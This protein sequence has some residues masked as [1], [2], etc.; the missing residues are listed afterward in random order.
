MAKVNKSIALA[1]AATYQQHITMA[2]NDHSLIKLG[3]YDVTLHIFEDTLPEL[4]RYR[5]ILLELG[6]CKKDIK[7]YFY[8]HD[9]KT[10]DFHT[11]CITI[12]FE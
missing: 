5:R 3:K 7:H 11:I 9:D 12:N 1:L 4:I 10:Q 6:V 8:G 2:G